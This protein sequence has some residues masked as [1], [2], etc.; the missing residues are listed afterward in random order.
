GQHGAQEHAEGGVE[1]ARGDGDPDGVVDERPEQVLFHRAHGA[2][3]EP[4]RGGDAGQI[5]AH[6]GD[7]AGLDGDVGPG[8]DGD[9][10]VGLGEG[11]RV[12]DPVADHRHD[13]PLGLEATD[14]L[15]LALGEDL[16]DDAGD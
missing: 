12:V 4:D 8:A 14:L 16:G 1:H 5:A 6:E 2:A 3:R 10:D 11:G 9:P 13:L 15:D 7:V